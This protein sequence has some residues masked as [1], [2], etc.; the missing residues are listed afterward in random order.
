MWFAA[1]AVVSVFFVSKGLLMNYNNMK[2]HYKVQSGF[3]F[4]EL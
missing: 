3:K 1:M 2:N 4:S